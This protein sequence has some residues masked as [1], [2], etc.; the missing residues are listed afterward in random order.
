MN[1]GRTITGREGKGWRLEGGCGYDY[2]PETT[3]DLLAH[4]DDH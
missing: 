1:R 2:V 3:Q 4:F